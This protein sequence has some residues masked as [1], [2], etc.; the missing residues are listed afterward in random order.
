LKP[1][2]IVY[3]PANITTDIMKLLKSDYFQAAFT[4]IYNY[5]KQPETTQ[6]KDTLAYHYLEK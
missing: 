6:W 4:P 2:E 1:T 5:E 3:D